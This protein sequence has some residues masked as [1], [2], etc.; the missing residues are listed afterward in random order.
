ML[1]FFRDKDPSIYRMTDQE[2]SFIAQNK[3]KN[4]FFMPRL[5][6][7]LFKEIDE[8]VVVTDLLPPVQ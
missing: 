8:L 5:I 1:N 4:N 3:L 7:E 6:G 2:R